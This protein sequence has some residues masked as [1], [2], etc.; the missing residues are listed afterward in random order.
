MNH[1]ARWIVAAVLLAGVTAVALSASGP[2]A[3]AVPVQR[4]PGN[5][6]DIVPGVVYVKFREG[7]RPAGGLL[8]K[9]ASPLMSRLAATGVTSL[10]RTFAS[11]RPL[12][13]AEKSAGTIDLSGIYTASIGSSDDP[14]AIARRLS[15][16]GEVEYAEPKYLCHPFDEPND[17]LYALRQRGYFTI[18]HAPE[19]WSV[20]HG[21]SSV[22]IAVVDGGTFWLHTDLWPKLRISV[23]EDVNHTGRFE[24][25]PPPAGDENGI[26]DDGNGYVDDVVGWNFANNSDD[27]RG[28]WPNT[29]EHGTETASVIGANTNNGTGM[30]GA[31]WS[32]RIM[33]V[34]AAAAGHD[35]DIAFGFEGILYAAR[36]GASVINCSWGREGFYSRVEQDVIT[37]ATQAG[38]LV[39]VAAGNSS[40]NN[41]FSPYY[42]AS[43][44]H[45][46]AVGVTL[47]SSDARATFSNYGITIP[48]YAPGTGIC[49]ATNNGTYGVD[50]G[51]SFSS[52]LT[53]ALAGLVKSLHPSWSPDQIASQIR[54]TSDSI[55]VTNTALAGSMGRGRVNYARAVTES[56]SGLMI[57]AASIRT[58][59]GRTAFLPGDTVAVRL[60]FRSLLQPAANITVTVSSWQGSL[61]TLRG[62][63]SVPAMNPGGEVTLPDFLFRVDTVSAVRTEVLKVEWVA[64]GNERDVAGYRINLFPSQ[65]LWV[66]QEA[67]AVGPLWS[68]CAV[69]SVVV[70]AAGGSTTGLSPGVI[71]TTDGG[72]TWADVTGNLA[73][74]VAYCIG[75]SD[76]AH[77]WVGT[78]DGRIIAT[79]DGGMTWVAQP[80][81]GAQSAFIDGIRFFDAQHGIA[82]GDP[83]SGG[84]FVLLETSNGG[85]EW[86]H[87]SSEPAA[88]AGEAGWSN[89]V[90][91]VDPLHG[92]FGTNSSRV[93]RTT[94]GGSTWSF[95]PSGSQNSTAIAFRDTLY[96]V[97][98]HDDGRVSVTT[99][100][101]ATWQG[102]TQ[103]FSGGIFGAAW[104]AGV[105]DVWIAPPDMPYRSADNGHSW[106]SETVYP[107]LGEIIDIAFA[108]TSHGWGVTSVGEVIRHGAGGSVGPPPYTLP[109]AFRVYQNYP[110]PFNGST[111]VTYDLP[112]RSSVEVTL[113]DLLGRRVRVLFSGV[114]GPGTPPAVHIDAAGLASGVYFY[115]VVANPV[116]SGN[117]TVRGTGKMILIR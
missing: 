88:A 67:P 56:H 17:S 42:P 63:A 30:A 84:T 64:N 1:G 111:S 28:I 93:Y 61:R 3:K 91:W 36:N 113:Y 51:T 38:A 73:G 68:V 69:D 10:E 78:G 101:G 82:L 40:A 46:L 71:R 114:Q 100:G 7:V 87:M 27:P 74:F 29:A 80:Y 108:D 5:P 19:A 58:P 25:G 102:I 31:A 52:P 70:W 48:V 57:T 94:D 59:T 21:D 72:V 16:L 13:T 26:D 18:L 99:D 92:W 15:L 12:P 103:I 35:D 43:Y 96:G 83:G 24:K 44:D 49:V 85:E 34:C 97:V 90:W 116:V 50:Q 47:S 6:A 81:P 11:E 105:P 37:A 76:S 77:A 8:L 115:Q 60:T 107:V 86:T 22:V 104:P 89:A 20:T 110:N 106:V 55:D 65:P 2:H 75:A 33:P 14:V 23:P 95:A 32:C 9:A 117:A 98:G 53:A 39:V 41:D 62:D 79:S 54:M 4:D 109:T 112:E 66:T 45:V